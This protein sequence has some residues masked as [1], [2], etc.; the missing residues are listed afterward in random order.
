MLIFGEHILLL[1]SRRTL[2][3]RSFFILLILC[4]YPIGHSVHAVNIEQYT[5][6][7]LKQEQIYNSLIH[8]LRCLVCQNQA[9]GDSNAELAQDMRQKTYQLIQQGYT[10]Q[11]IADF[12]AD[13]YG[14]FVLYNTPFKASTALLWIAPTLFLI[15]AI[16]FFLRYIHRQ[17]AIPITHPQHDD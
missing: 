15:I 6:S 10:K 12:M 16:G 14:D 7:D 11:Q 17:Q 8:E 5:F 4:G 13:R 2:T 3:M 9:I 1:F